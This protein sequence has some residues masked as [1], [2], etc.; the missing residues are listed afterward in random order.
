MAKLACEA[1]VLCLQEVHGLRGD[2][3]LAIARLLPGWKVLD[4]LAIRRDGTLDPHSGGFAV[5]LCPSLVR[6]ANSEIQ[7]G[8]WPLPSKLG[9]RTS[10]IVMSTIMV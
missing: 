7:P 9:T 5:L 1:H 3:G 4:S 6:V 10:L 2:V 8:S